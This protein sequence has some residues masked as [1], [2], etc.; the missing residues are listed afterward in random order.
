MRLFFALEPDSNTA[1]DLADWRDRQLPLAGRPVPMANLHITL[2]FLGEFSPHRL[3]A[4]CLS[5]DDFL[6]RT[7]TGGDSLV[8]DQIGY[9]QKEHPLTD[10]RP[11]HNPRVIPRPHQGV[12]QHQGY[13][14]NRQARPR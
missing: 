1:I 10:D 11:A 13:R 7:G 6:L 12:H 2:S 3:E 4:L 9:W 8:L 5:V 14:L